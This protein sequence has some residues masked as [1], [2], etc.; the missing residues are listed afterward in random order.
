MRFTLA[1]LSAA[2]TYAAVFDREYSGSDVI[3]FAGR[4]CFDAWFGDDNSAHK[5]T[6]NIEITVTIPGDKKNVFCDEGQT[7]NCYINALLFSDEPDSWP[8]LYGKDGITCKD[9]ITKSKECTTKDCKLTAASLKKDGDDYTYT[10][11][12]PITEQYV[13]WW[14][15]AVVACREGKPLA[16]D[17]LTVHSE[18]LNSQRSDW[19]KQLGFDVFGLNTFYLTIFFLFLIF[20]CVHMYG[21]YN[22]SSK[23]EYLH[24]MVKLFAI[25]LTVQ[26]VAI[27]CN[28]LHWSTYSK[29]GVGLLALREVGEVVDSITRVIFML[30]LTLMGK[31]WT[32]SGDELTHGKP[33]IGALVLFLVIHSAVMLWKFQLED[34]AAT[35][36][37]TGLEVF[38]WFELLLWFLFG[39]FFSI[40]VFQSWKKE[41]N[42]VKRRLYLQLGIV[43][44]IWMFIYPILSLVNLSNNGDRDWVTKEQK[45]TS[46]TTLILSMIGYV[47]LSFLLWPSRAEEYFHINKPDVM[48]ANIDTYEQL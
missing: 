2:V 39:G 46:E 28:M 12:K 33:I 18:F 13:R 5:I 15:S 20:Y 30:I 21:V 48:R 41:E 22:I 44:S 43:F 16:M 34:P 31:G 17:G 38:L 36:M 24:P 27:I 23:L 10:L 25:C 6:G 14:F 8:S 29:N 7:D 4:F 35:S 9:A 1:L 45:V 11:T 32:I 37:D 42:P 47:F 40:T 3:N 26:F 19:S